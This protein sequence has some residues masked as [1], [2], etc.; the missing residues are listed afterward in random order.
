MNED[1]FFTK[2]PQREIPVGE[3]NRERVR[4]ITSVA[5]S[6]KGE[7]VIEYGVADRYPRQ[8]MMVRFGG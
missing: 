6:V 2:A 4:G 7:R 5:D 1:K 8:R 3:R